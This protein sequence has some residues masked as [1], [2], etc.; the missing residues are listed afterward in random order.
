MQQIDGLTQE[1]FKPVLGK[2]SL[3]RSKDGL[4]YQF[5]DSSKAFE[6]TNTCLVQL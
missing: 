6:D 3:W 4:Y 5:K 1:L 2:R